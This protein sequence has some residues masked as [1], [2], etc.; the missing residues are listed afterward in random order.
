MYN[1]K[2]SFKNAAFNLCKPKFLHSMSVAIVLYLESMKFSI[3]INDFF[4]FLLYHLMEEAG[5]NVLSDNNY[6]CQNN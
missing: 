6:L 4:S 5:R 2:E 3:P 1:K